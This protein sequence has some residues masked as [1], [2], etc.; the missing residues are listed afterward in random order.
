MGS[1]ISGFTGAPTLAP[2]LSSNVASP[3]STGLSA[4]AADLQNAL[5]RSIGL[6]ALPLTLLQNQQLQLSS[7]SSALTV[8]STQFSVLQSAITNL[9]SAA[10]NVVSSAVSDA[11]VLSASAAAG[12]L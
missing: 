2:S 9:N 10:S 8:L 7:E 4:Y 3:A 6:A 5:N 11:S 12:A 1:P